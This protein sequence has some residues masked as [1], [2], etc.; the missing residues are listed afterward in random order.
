MTGIRRGLAQFAGI[1]LALL[2]VGCSRPGGEVPGAAGPTP[3]EDPRAKEMA[4]QA[5]AARQ[6]AR[7]SALQALST[8]AKSVDEMEQTA[9]Y[10]ARGLAGRG[11]SVR[12]YFVQSTGPGPRR[13]V[14]SA[15]REDVAEAATALYGDRT[16]SLRLGVATE[17]WAMP[18]SLTFKTDEELW[19]LPLEK[20]D[21]GPGR[22]E[23]PI[24]VRSPELA[25]ALATAKRIKMRL[26]SD[27]STD[28]TLPQ[29]QVAGLAQ[30]YKVWLPLFCTNVISDCKDAEP[31]VPNP[32]AGLSLP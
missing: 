19:Q 4:E 12:F 29:S 21:G 31:Q 17:A 14:P 13:A 27:S 16:G 2:A 25:K 6:A 28:F 32:F 22:F 9:T 20:G 7:R 24:A 23:V 8:L 15:Q 3:K 1:V 5:E 18:E 30:V 26:G 10:S 11:K